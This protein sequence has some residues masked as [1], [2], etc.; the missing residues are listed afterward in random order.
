MPIPPSHDQADCCQGRWYHKPL[1]ERTESCSVTCLRPSI[2]QAFFALL[3]D[4]VHIVLAVDL[5]VSIELGSLFITLT[6]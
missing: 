3:Q 5:P 6:I 1:S 2:A 4:L